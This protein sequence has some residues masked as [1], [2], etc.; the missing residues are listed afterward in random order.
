MSVTQTIFLSMT[1]YNETWN[2]SLRGKKHVPTWTSM[3]TLGE[4]VVL[5]SVSPVNY[6]ISLDLSELF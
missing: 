3:Y 1:F 2:D 6:C 5:K 4:N